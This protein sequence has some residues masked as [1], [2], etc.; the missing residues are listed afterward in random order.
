M[1]P[2]KVVQNKCLRKITGGYKRTPS[3]ALERE[4]G[5]SPLDLYTEATAFQR[6][7]ITLFITI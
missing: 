7:R 2:L 1:Q 5:I 4:A 3:A 6:P